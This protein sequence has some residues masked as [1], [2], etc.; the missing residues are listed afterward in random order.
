P[1][2]SRAGKASTK[3]AHAAPIKQ[4]DQG[5]KIHRSLLLKRNA[6]SLFRDPR[7]AAAGQHSLMR[8]FAI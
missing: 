5:I 1:D 7:P 3:Q 6:S 8:R 4:F 2:P